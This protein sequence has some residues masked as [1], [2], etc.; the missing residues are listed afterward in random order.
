MSNGTS[1]ATKQG[2]SGI[3]KKG[4]ADDF[5]ELDKEPAEKA[6]LP[7]NAM[8]DVDPNGKVY[9]GLEK[10]GSG[11]SGEFSE[12]K[13][14]GKTKKGSSGASSHH[15]VKSGSTS[16]QGED[17]ISHKQPTEKQP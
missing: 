2:S 17:D 8:I 12:K 10:N 1:Y 9:S 7:A 15:Y 13:Q 5:D 16:P 14:K 3:A 6:E 11:D 4:N